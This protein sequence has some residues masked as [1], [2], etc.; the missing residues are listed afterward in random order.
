MILIQ[1][2]P[3]ELHTPLQG[4]V[5][6]EGRTNGRSGEI[7]ANLSQGYERLSWKADIAAT[8]QGD[9]HAPDYLLTNTGKKEWSTGVG[10]RYHLHS[11]DI[12]AYYSHFFQ[13]LGILKGSVNGSLED[14][15]HAISE[16]PPLYTAPF[17]YEIGNP[18]QEVTHDLLKLKSTFF[19]KKHSF[20]FQYGFQNNLR[21]EFDVRRGTNNEIPAID[22]ELKTHSMEG[23]WYHPEADNHSGSVGVQFQF[24]E[25]KNIFG[26]NTISFVP[27]YTQ[28]RAGIFAIESWVLSSS[29]IEAGVRYDYQYNSII[30]LDAQNIQYVDQFD[31]NNLTATLGWIKNLSQNS[32]FR[33]NIG[34]AWRAPNV[35]ELY[36]Y[37]RHQSVFDYGFWRYET[38]SNGNVDT[39]IPVLTQNEKPVHSEKGFKWLNTLNVNKE[40]T[41]FELTGYVNFIQN[42]FYSQPAGI[43]SNVRGVFPFFIWKQDDAL[44]WGIDASATFQHRPRIQSEVKGSYVWAQQIDTKDVFVGIPPPVLSYQLTIHPFSSSKFTSQLQFVLDY[45]FKQNRAPRV[46]TISELI[47]SGET[48]TDIFASDSSNFDILPAPEGYLL[49]IF[50]GILNSENFH[51]Q[52]NLEIC[53]M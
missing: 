22:L 48:G 19:G 4:S 17:S 10:L 9:L 27:N 30:G 8:Q 3:F 35:A 16:E 38:D 32:T 41:N 25:N 52:F 20:L 53:S 1:P 46:I 12:E 7:N 26:T 40:K 36:A 37:G 34:T 21:K 50:F 51:F 14:L 24:Q 47:D 43:T 39:D 18:Q 13:N 29:S 45:T 11:A 49:T 23:I 5:G 15:E 2:K 33:T 6:L 31:F 28:T 44:F 42:Y